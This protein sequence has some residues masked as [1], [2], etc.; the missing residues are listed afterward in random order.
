MGGTTDGSG[1]CDR[2]TYYTDGGSVYP[3]PINTPVL[4]GHFAVDPL[5]KDAILILP[6]T[7][8]DHDKN[9]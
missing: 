4:Q 5:P 8:N 3:T 6:T 1:D 9:H 2:G 7:D